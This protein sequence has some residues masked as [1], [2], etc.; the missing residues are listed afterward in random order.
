MKRKGFVHSRQ[1]K[2]VMT[3]LA[4][5]KRMYGHLPKTIKPGHEL[6]GK[7]VKKYDVRVRAL[8]PG[9]RIS[10]TGKSYYEYRRNHA[11]LHPAQKL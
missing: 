3:K 9:K 7:S 5:M 6:E 11:D 8:K 1:R 4:K 2:A 10:K